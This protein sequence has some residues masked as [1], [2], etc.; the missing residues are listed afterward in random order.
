L[1]AYGAAYTLQ[2]MLTV[3]SDDVAG[4]V[5]TYESIVKGKNIPEPG[6]PASFKVLIKD[7]KAL[8]LDVQVFNNEDVKPTATSIVED[9]SKHL[10]TI[11]DKQEIKHKAVGD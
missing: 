11:Q 4:R 3:K 2:E 1:E 5:R 10:E 8:A 9:Y 6:V 7:L